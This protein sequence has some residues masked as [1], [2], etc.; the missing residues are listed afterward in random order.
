MDLRP[1]AVGPSVHLSSVSLVFV[2]YQSGLVLRR[3]AAALQSV[4]Y[5]ELVERLKCTEEAVG[6]FRRGF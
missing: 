6:V 2:V 5:S 4:R 1:E 3:V